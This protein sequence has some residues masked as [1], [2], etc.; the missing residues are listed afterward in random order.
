[1]IRTAWPQAA[2]LAVTFLS[3]L[4]V[5]KRLSRN[6]REGQPAIRIDPAEWLDFSDLAEGVPYA[7]ALLVFFLAHEFGH[8]IAGRRHGM[9][10]TLPYFIPDPIG[11]GVAGAW[12]RV[13]SLIDSRRA[14]L[15]FAIAGPLAGF[16]ALVPFL[17]LGLRWS[18]VQPESALQ[19]DLYFATPWLLSWLAG[20]YFPGVPENDIYLHPVARAA[21]IGLTATAMN[22]LPVG[23]L[24]GGH[25]VYAL[26][27]RLH[28]PVTWTGLAILALLGFA[29][30]PWW[31]LAGAIGIAF[32]K[33][34]YIHGPLRAG[35]L[36]MLF[37]LL[38]AALFA[39]CFT[40]APVQYD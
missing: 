18:K 25:I 26:A 15:D 21:W 13:R 36:R 4:A 32:R 19:G 7:A 2:L 9:E 12:V 30:S 22:L 28:K 24:D 23:Q 11:F 33:H 10:V 17:V 6:F 29:Y 5:G 31:L 16:L 37:A 27:P 14:L 35:W 1:M 38:S 34:P 20:L 39:M 8:Y 40:A 3:S